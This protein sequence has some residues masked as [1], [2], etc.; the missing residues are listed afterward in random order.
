MDKNNLILMENI[1]KAYETID[2]EKSMNRFIFLI[3]KR[4]FFVDVT[5]LLMNG[6]YFEKMEN[7]NMFNDIEVIVKRLNLEISIESNKYQDLFK[8]LKYSKH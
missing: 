6:G 5:A 1:K 7:R 3:A 4:D 2:S 8:E